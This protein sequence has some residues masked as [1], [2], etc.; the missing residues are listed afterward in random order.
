MLLPVFDVTLSSRVPESF[1]EIANQNF[2]PTINTTW[3]LLTKK[4][5]KCPPQAPVLFDNNVAWSAPLIVAA[6]IAA[7]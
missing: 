2:P 1:L 7:E 5:S 4:C 3:L 6:G